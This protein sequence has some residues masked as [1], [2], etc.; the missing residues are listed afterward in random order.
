[1]G[2]QRSLTVSSGV[3]RICRS[4][5]HPV[6]VFA[7]WTI[8]VLMPHVAFSQ[9]APDFVGEFAGMLGPLHVKLHLTTARDGMLSGTVDS[10]DQNMFGLPCAD[11][12]ANGQ[13]LSFTVPMVRGTW[14]GL[15]SGDGS[16][17]SG[18]WS[19]GSPIPLNLTRVTSAAATSTAT[20]PAALP[21]AIAGA[22]PAATT[23]AQ[24]IACGSTFAVNYWDGDRWKPMVMTAHVGSE[25]GVSLANGLKNPFNPSAG[26]TK[27]VTLKNPAATLTLEPKPKFCM[28]FL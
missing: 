17:L 24:Q 28:E 16:S 18:V 8:A 1:M 22:A 6:A 25:R 13:A 23:A 14:T 5:A 27:I 15:L 10:P 4:L 26:I 3:G 2:F 19:Q 7:V 20:A 21:S 11:I 9:Q 12:H